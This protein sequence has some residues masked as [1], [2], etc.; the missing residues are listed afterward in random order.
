MTM[1][2][3]VLCLCLCFSQIVLYFNDCLPLLNTYWTIACV[4]LFCVTTKNYISR[5]AKKFDKF[6]GR[7][8]H[9]TSNIA[10]VPIWYE[11]L[12]WLSC[13]GCSALNTKKSRSICKPHAYHGAASCSH[14]TASTYPRGLHTVIVSVSVSAYTHTH[15]AIRPFFLSIFCCFFFVQRRFFASTAAVEWYSTDSCA[16]TLVFSWNTNNNNNNHN[17]KR[18]TV[19]PCML[20][21]S[22]GSHAVQA[23]AASF[24]QRTRYVCAFTA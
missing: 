24:A 23:G 17:I 16:F 6:V 14:S 2:A 20:S 1:C 11:W 8:A 4:Y 10:I 19:L 22:F 3:C 9:K 7:T 18:C 5:F 21:L 15:S 13:G 12:N